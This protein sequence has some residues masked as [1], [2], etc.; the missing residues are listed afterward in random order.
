MKFINAEVLKYWI[1]S[2][3]KEGQKKVSLSTIMNII[4][5]QKAVQLES[6]VYCKDCIYATDNGLCLYFNFYPYTDDYCSRGRRKQCP[7]HR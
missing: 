1:K 2:R 3:T 4:E 7:P 6:V 5:C